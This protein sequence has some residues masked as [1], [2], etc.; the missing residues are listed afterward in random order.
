[1]GLVQIVALVIVLISFGCSVSTD[2]DT[3]GTFIETTNGVAGVMRTSDSSVAVAAK[4]SL[5]P[6]GYLAPMGGDT[7]FVN[8]TTETNQVGYFTI[9]SIEPGEYILEIVGTD[10]MQR[11]SELSVPDDTTFIA[12][13]EYLAQP[14]MV[15]G[16]LKRYTSAPVGTTYWVQIYGLDRLLP[17]D[18]LGNYSGYLPAGEHTLRL[19]TS[20][21]T[22][23]SYDY[24][25]FTALPGD[26]LVIDS[27]GVYTVVSSGSDM[28][29]D[30]SSSHQS[31]I[32]S[33]EVLLSSEDQSVSSSQNSSLSSEGTM[34]SAIILESS[35]S[36][37]EL[38]SS[39]ELVISSSEY[40]L[41]LNPLYYNEL[42]IVFSGDTV[43][44]LGSETNLL[45]PGMGNFSVAFNFSYVDSSIHYLVM[46]GN[47][48]S[49]Y[50]GWSFFVEDGI[51][52][53]RVNSSDDDS[54]KAALSYA[55]SE[56][57][58]NSVISVVGVVDRANGVL[59]A[60][61]NGSKA[62]WIAGGGGT[63]SE[64]VSG[65]SAIEI[66]VPITVAGAYTSDELKGAGYHRGYIGDLRIF[67][68]TLSAEDVEFLNVQ[69]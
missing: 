30:Q 32:S 28:S 36:M 20:A 60:Y 23:L 50:A 59:V 24:A 49:Y 5:R 10:T 66:G 37:S 42:G 56:D 27:L 11:M 53:W 47:T 4:V 8:Y 48:L 54:E 18:S 62:G 46:K 55:L 44:N 15:E 51:L 41:S 61:L 22:L 52:N 58:E 34:S 21:T 16:V 39:V 38:S 7:R 9:D 63:V 45:E 1:M 43:L 40:V 35:S 69:K 25:Q 33:T 17:A 13:N 2:G 29:S 12:V 14:V 64:S 57:L 19:I 6:K 65:L 26:Q 67:N 31:T 3:A 68:D